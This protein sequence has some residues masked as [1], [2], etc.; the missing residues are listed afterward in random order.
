MTCAPVSITVRHSFATHLMDHGTGLR[1]VQVLLGHGK[2]KS[3]EIYTN[4][5]TATILKIR[6]PLAN[7]RLQNKG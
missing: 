2:S 3:T 4:V 5:S 1:Q 7:I 6:S